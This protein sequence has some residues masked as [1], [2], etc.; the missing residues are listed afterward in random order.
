MSPR[1]R[2]TVY[3]LLFLSLGIGLRTRLGGLEGVE[4]IRCKNL[5]ITDADG[6]VV[7][8]C[9]SQSNGHG[10]LEFL[11]DQGHILAAAGISPDGKSGQF[12]ILGA[13]GKT[14]MILRSSQRGGNLVALSADQ[15]LLLSLGHDEETSGVFVID[16]VTNQR[17]GVQFLP[18]I[19]KLAPVKPENVEP[20]PTPPADK[21]ADK[22]EE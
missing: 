10:Q 1:E 6:K 7:V 21:P 11:D 9:G 4:S 20:K 15:K 5:T 8:H 13:D 12:V 19:R 18:I 17:A 22:P 16:P 14:E 3:P 2:W